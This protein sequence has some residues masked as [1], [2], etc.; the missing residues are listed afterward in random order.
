MPWVGKEEE[1]L[2][3]LQFLIRRQIY[4]EGFFI[5]LVILLII[6]SFF[7]LQFS[8]LRIQ[9]MI[10]RRTRRMTRSEEGRRE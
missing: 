8:I 1:V 4:A 2:G 7:L 9:R 10:R 5:L 3:G 6:L